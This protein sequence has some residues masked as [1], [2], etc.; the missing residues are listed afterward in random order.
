MSLLCPIGPESNI[1]DPNELY[2]HRLFLP[3]PIL[4]LDDLKVIKKTQH[5]GWKTKVI[6]ATYPVEEGPFSLVKTLNRIN[7]EANQAARNGYQIIILSDRK[8]G[9]DR[10]ITLIYN[11]RNTGGVPRVINDHLMTPNK[12]CVFIL[13][14]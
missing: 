8:G 9:P 14:N 4:S 11:S 7:N 6:D 10:Y 1:L 2:V 13:I 12:L 5:R 3:Q